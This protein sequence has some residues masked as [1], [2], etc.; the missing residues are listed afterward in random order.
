MTRLRWP[1][2]YRRW[3]LA[4]TMALA[5]RLDTLFAAHRGKLILLFW[6]AMAFAL[7]MA[8]LPKPPPIPGQPTDKIQ[9]IAAFAVLTILSVPAY[10]A[11]RWMTRFGWLALFGALIEVGQMIPA[12]GRSADVADW[13][14]DSAAILI[15]MGITALLDRW[16]R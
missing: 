12:L 6:V 14:A 16:L 10:P 9:H 3:R 2:C 4:E 15:T 11:W 13:L 8:L 5:V 7:V 1:A